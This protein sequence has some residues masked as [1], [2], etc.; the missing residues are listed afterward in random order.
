MKL[1]SEF[2]NQGLELPADSVGNPSGVRF[3]PDKDGVINLPDGLEKYGEAAARGAP[4]SI[5]GRQWGGFGEGK[6]PKPY[7]TEGLDANP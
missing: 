2:R 1:K 7:R 3:K 4:F 6:M 5:V